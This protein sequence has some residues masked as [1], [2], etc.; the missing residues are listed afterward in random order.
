MHHE[1]RKGI[2]LGRRLKTVFL[3]GHRLRG[4][5]HILL[6]PRKLRLHYG[7]HR[8]RDRRILCGRAA[9]R[10]SPK[11]RRTQSKRS[12]ISH[13][14]SQHTSSPVHTL[15][16]SDSLSPRSILRVPFRHKRPHISLRSAPIGHTSV[17]IGFIPN[18][19]RLW[20]GPY[21]HGKRRFSGRSS[22]FFV[23]ATLAAPLF[24]FAF[25]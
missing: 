14:L 21:S 8:I 9:H 24:D 1:V 3:G 2:H 23:V 18:A 10:Q 20:R 5:H 19:N 15:S 25:T 12:Q 7:T 13:G 17:K 11:A 6:E 22:L 16:F 4:P